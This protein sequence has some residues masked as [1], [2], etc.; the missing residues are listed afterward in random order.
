M[1]QR[2]YLNY[3]ISEC[4]KYAKKNDII[5]I[6]LYGSS[7]KGKEE[8]RDIDILIIFKDK[9]LNERTNIAQN[10][11]EILRKKIDKI[12]IK[13]INLKEFFEKDFL[14]RQGILIEGHSLVNNLPFAEK[15]G[16]KG[17]SLFTYNL[18]NLVHKE[19]TKFT[20]ALIGRNNI[21]IIKQLDGT[22]LGRG[23]FLIPIKNSLIFEKFLEKWNI[24]YNKKNILVAIQ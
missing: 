19:K 13:T 9:N 6:V 21:G 11:K 18:K 20:Y 2:D 14:A 15:I 24:N 10:L 5:D 8:V 1:M 23:A 16:F 12:D 4:R 17:Y 22:S 3:L 7:V